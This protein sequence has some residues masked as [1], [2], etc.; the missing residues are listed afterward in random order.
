MTTTFATPDKKPATRD[1]MVSIRLTP[2]Q[3]AAVTEL[4]NGLEVTKAELI[5]RA[6]DLWVQ[7]HRP[8]HTR[9]RR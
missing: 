6:L 8:A 9:R 4:A 1:V 7:K 3:D 2:E 5:R